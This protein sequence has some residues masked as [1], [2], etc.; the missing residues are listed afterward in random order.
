MEWQFCG[1]EGHCW[2][3]WFWGTS[4]AAWAQAIATVFVAWLAIRGPWKERQHQRAKEVLAKL[5]DQCRALSLIDECRETLRLQSAGL[6]ALLE[7]PNLD[8][9]EIQQ[10]QSR[11]IVQDQACSAIPAHEYG[12]RKFLTLVLEVLKW[13]RLVEL[14]I[15][16]LL[17]A[18]GRQHTTGSDLMNLVSSWHD[19]GQAGSNALKCCRSV[20][21]A[22]PHLAEISSGI[23][24]NLRQAYGEINRKA[25]AA[26]S[27][28]LLW[29]R[30]FWRRT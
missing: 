23:D 21:I 18:A 11:L 26:P 12:N 24:S 9:W 13:T 25:W 22:A 30:A 14:S 27:C 2:A 19:Y 10:I 20:E 17:Q 1:L 8:L 16:E 7:S 4:A 3:S 6:K 15:D 5:D 28:R 29:K